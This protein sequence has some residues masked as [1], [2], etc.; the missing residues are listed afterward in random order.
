MTERSVAKL[1]A[2]GGMALVRAGLVRVGHAVAEATA[3]VKNRDTVGFWVDYYDL[4]AGQ[5]GY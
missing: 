1:S 2:V 3:S 4:A 5:D